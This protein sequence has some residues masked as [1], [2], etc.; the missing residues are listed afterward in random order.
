MNPNENKPQTSWWG[1]LSRFAKALIIFGPIATVVILLLIFGRFPGMRSHESVNLMKF[2]ADNTS[3]NSSVQVQMLPVPKIDQIEYS[4]IDSPEYSIIHWIWMGNAPLFTANGGSI[5]LKGS[6][7]EKCGIRLKLRCN[8]SVDFM[9]S[10]QLAFINAYAKGDKAPTVGSPFVTL[11]GDGIPPY[12]STMNAAIDKAVGKE[13]RLKAVGMWAWS[14]GE[15]CGMGSKELL[16]NKAALK[17]KIFIA[18][19]G[20]GDWALLVRLAA[21]NTDPSDPNGGSIRVNPDPTTFDPEAL[22]FVPA[23]D[24]D[25]LKAADQYIAGTKVPLKV[26]NKNGKLTGEEKEFIPD[27]CAT[28]FPG[29]LNVIRKTGG[30]K[31]ISTKEYPN[32]MATTLVGPDKWMKEHSDV[33]VKILSGA[34]IAANQMKNYDEW[35]RYACELAPGVF[36]ANPASAP[37]QAKDFYAYCK[38]GGTMLDPDGLPLKNKT[39]DNVSIG[40][41]QYA[42]LAD[43]RKYYGLDGGN[44]Y[45]R[46]VYTYFADAITKLNPQN[47]MGD[48]DGMTPYEDAVDLTYL[49]QVDV[50]PGKVTEVDMSKNTG[51]VFS[52]KQWHIEFVLGSAAITREGA[53]ELEK[54]YSQMCISTNAVV[55]IK[56]HTDN[57]GTPEGNKILSEQRAMAVKIWLINRSNN[58]FAENR[59]GAIT[60]VGSSEPVNPNVNNDLKINRDHNRR[61]S[62]QFKN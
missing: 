34:L 51:N 48:I 10:E 40:G 13:Y 20:D 47:V 57:T 41:T 33:V 31:F 14:M 16:Q 2:S 39:G 45:Y 60:G 15:D 6:I 62:I 9:K 61:V 54:L 49:K 35:F 53:K 37:F 21:D 19:I 7:M 12:I 44:D 38:P 25:F 1:N 4:T 55:D 56:G 27:G 32:Q 8:N 5:T 29:D 42:N 23:Q 36:Y 17:G 58:Q 30:I 26:K 18:V 59:F 3:I 43:V 52:T 11:M 50:D 46:A 24:N 28:W 22:N